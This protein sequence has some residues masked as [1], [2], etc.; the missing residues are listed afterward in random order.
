MR[1]RLQGILIGILLTV[2]VSC[3]VALASPKMVEV[4]FD[5]I[6]ISINGKQVQSDTEPFIYNDRTYIPARAVAEGMGGLVNWNSNTNTVEINTVQTNSND[7][8][9]IKDYYDAIYLLGTSTSLNETEQHMLSTSNLINLTHYQTGFS[10]VLNVYYETYINVSDTFDKTKNSYMDC[11][12]SIINNSKNEKN[13]EVAKTILAMIPK[14][15]ASINLTQDL[16]S[17]YNP[18]KHLIIAR[19]AADVTMSNADI[20]L[21]IY[22][23]INKK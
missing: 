5:N 6:K 23:N 19:N 8:D 15:E 18:D 2:I 4:L 3:T 21:Q 16:F 17:D 12:N 10:K 20:K 14:V 1:Q 9:T 11:A 22:N 13:I 7:T